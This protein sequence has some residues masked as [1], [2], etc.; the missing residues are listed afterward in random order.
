MPDVSAAGACRPGRQHQA[1]AGRPGT[2]PAL[3]GQPPVHRLGEPLLGV[4]VV[5]RLDASA[6]AGPLA[7]ALR[8]LPA[9]EREVLL[10]V[11]WEELTPAQAAAALGTALGARTAL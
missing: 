10:L 7:A 9:A 11:A 4:L 3:D 6:R 2:G 1:D 5:D 8:A